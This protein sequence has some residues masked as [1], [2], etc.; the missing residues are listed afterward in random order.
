M[1]TGKGHPVDL[2]ELLNRRVSAHYGDLCSI[3]TCPLRKPFSLAYLR[4][5]AFHKA[6]QVISLVAAGMIVSCIGTLMSVSAQTSIDTRVAL[7]E[8]QQHSNEYEQ[9]RLLNDVDALRAELVAEREKRS[10]LDSRISVMQGVGFGLGSI[11]M[12]LQAA[13]MLLGLKKKTP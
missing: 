9:T 12:V 8:S 13:S 1:V 6:I 11:V 5:L 10:E 4:H 2:Q 3:R 7:V